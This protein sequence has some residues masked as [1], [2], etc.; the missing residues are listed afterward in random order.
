LPQGPS[1]D[2]VITDERPIL[3]RSLVYGYPAPG[4]ADKDY[5][6]FMVLDSYLR[7]ADRSPITFW[8]P[9]REQA[10]SVG[11]MYPSYPRRSTLAV[12]L[13]AKPE[14]YEAARDTVAAVFEMLKTAPFDKGEWST[15]IKRVQNGFFWKQNQPVIRA[16][17]LSRWEVQGLTTEF[18]RNFETA[19][20]QLK[21]EDVRDA[22]ARWFTHAATVSLKPSGRDGQP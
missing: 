10:A 12:Y 14:K 3:A 8:M 19:L 21:P 11:V 7:S 16:R 22:A 9:Q 1:E 6:A 18:P 2:T 13:A 20:L 15:Q 5:A 17:N 4:Y